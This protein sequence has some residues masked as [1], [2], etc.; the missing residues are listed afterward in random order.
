[1]EYTKEL[2]INVYEKTNSITCWHI[3]NVIVIIVSI[4]ITLI[5]I[6]RRTK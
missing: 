1:M 4:L 3:I 6:K 2:H 5:I